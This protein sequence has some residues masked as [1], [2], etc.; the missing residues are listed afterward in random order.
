MDELDDWD[1]WGEEGWTLIDDLA[2]EEEGLY[3]REPGPQPLRWQ[4]LGFLQ[5]A[6]VVIMLLAGVEMCVLVMLGV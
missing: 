3:G 1:S 4:N 2:V 6:F 5:K